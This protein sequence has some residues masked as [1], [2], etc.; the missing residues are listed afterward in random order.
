ML[1]AAGYT[2]TSYQFDWVGAPY[3]DPNG[4]DMDLHHWLQ[5]TFINSNWTNTLQY[6]DTLFGTRGY[7]EVVN[8]DDDTNL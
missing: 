4:N 3:D 1:W 7:P 6:L 8:F 2:N 5:L